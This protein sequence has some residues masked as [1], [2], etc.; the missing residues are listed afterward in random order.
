MSIQA[1]VAT[2]G[3]ADQDLDIA[4]I[5]VLCLLRMEKKRNLV[6]R[7]NVLHYVY[8]SIFIPLPNI[9]IK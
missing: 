8:V 1:T 5:D 6:A 7:T 9:L 4:I 3:G 2:F